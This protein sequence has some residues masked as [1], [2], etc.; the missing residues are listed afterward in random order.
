MKPGHAPQAVADRLGDPQI[1]GAGLSLRVRPHLQRADTRWERRLALA[2]ARRCSHEGARPPLEP[3]AGMRRAF[4]ETGVS[5][6]FGRETSCRV[7]AGPWTALRRQVRVLAPEETQGVRA[8][9]DDDVRAYGVARPA[10]GETR[11][12]FAGHWGV[13]LCRRHGYVACSALASG[14]PVP[15]LSRR[16]ASPR[17]TWT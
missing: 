15:L 17:S 11:D 5:A 4:G 12:R 1:L 9:R 8:D 7:K 3:S 10:G 2:P 6:D 16:R 13:L 14:Q